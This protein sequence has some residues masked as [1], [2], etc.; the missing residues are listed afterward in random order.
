[1]PCAVAAPRA[2]VGACCGSPGTCLGD[3]KKRKK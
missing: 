3:E 2:A 1:M